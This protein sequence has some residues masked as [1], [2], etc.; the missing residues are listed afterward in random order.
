MKPKTE[1]QKKVV[2][3]SSQ[4]PKITD[5][6]NQYSIDKSFLNWGVISR[7]K[8]NCLECGNIWKDNV[9]NWHNE[10]IGY[11]CPNCKSKLKMFGQNKSYFE[12][13]EYYSILTTIE[14]FQVVRMILSV[15]QMKKTQSPTYYHV[16][17]MQHFIDEKGNVTSMAKK[18]QVMSH[19]Y[20]LWIQGSELE[21]QNKAF[22]YR[23]LFRLNPY[24]IYPTKKILPIIKRNGFKTS[25]YT[26]APQEL[27][28]QLLSSNTAETLLKMKQI[29]VLKYF[30][31]SNS[32]EV[33][34]NWNSIKIC[35]KNN[36]IIK[37]FVL[38]KDYINLIK[39]FGK[40]EKNVKYICPINLKLS[41]DKLVEKKRKVQLAMKIEEMK[42]MIKIS[43]KQYQKTK[44]A[45]FGLHFSDGEIVVKVMESVKEFLIEGDTHNHCVFTNEYFNKKE[46]LILTA[47]IG[48]TKLE[49]IEVSLENFSIVQARGKG[50]KSTKHNGKIIKLVTQNLS[51][52]KQIAMKKAV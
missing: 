1:L 27:F 10:M 51:K 31:N 18:R 3:L 22:R 25:F 6:Q 46:S 23:N 17:V 32:S 50:N 38:W 13:K 14:N 8:T 21:V 30:I 36:Y 52:I 33:V 41:H 28:A 11:T 39:Y 20:D 45:F 40:D 48:N 37:D 26:I 16:E 19:Y 42:K 34:S 47:S 15:K 43:E 49:T 5:K 9:P 4:L 24:V 12:E 35:T 2:E 7:G 29:N 44:K